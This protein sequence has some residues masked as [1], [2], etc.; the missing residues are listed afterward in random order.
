[1]I[2]PAVFHLLLLVLVVK[3]Y[4]RPGINRAGTVNLKVERFSRFILVFQNIVA[5]KYD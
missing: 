5:N 2:V 1:L 3:Y 4:L